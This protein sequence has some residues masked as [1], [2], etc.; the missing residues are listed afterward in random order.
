[1]CKGLSDQWR[2]IIKGIGV[3]DKIAVHR[4]CHDRELGG[5]CTIFRILM[6]GIAENINRY[7]DSKG[8]VGRFIQRISFSDHLYHLA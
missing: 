1:M 2:F 3:S 6:G 5:Q 4:Q 7:A 8:H